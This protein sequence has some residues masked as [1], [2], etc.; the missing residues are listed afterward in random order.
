[1]Q[2]FKMLALVKHPDKNPNDPNAAA[3]FDEL[4]RC[5]DLL[6]DPQAKAALD[7]LFEYAPCS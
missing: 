7:D 6:L 3:A 2:A 4:K 5:R 1:M